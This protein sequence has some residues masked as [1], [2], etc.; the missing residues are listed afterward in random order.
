MAEL[1]EAK[2]LKELESVSEMIEEYGLEPAEVSQALQQFLD[3][4]QQEASA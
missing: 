4:K 2:R 3:S 1:M